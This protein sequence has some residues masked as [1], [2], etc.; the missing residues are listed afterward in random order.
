VVEDVR[1][2]VLS[3]LLRPDG[4][5]EGTRQH[6]LQ[7]RPHRQRV[8]SG[9]QVNGGAHQRHPRHRSVLGETG[10]FSRLEADE[11]V[12]QGRVGHDRNLRLQLDDVMDSVQGGHADALQQQLAG[13]RGPVESTPARPRTPA[14][15][16]VRNA[17][18]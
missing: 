1:Y 14:T 18:T 7:Q 11:P 15:C 5:S 9:H 12:P 4:S 8:V 6:R 3:E 16:H 10:Q 13:Q 17:R 2:V